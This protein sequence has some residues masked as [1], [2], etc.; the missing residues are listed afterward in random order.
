MTTE[1]N[2]T[3]PW[4]V[5]ESGYNLVDVNLNY[6][7]RAFGV[8]GLGLK[9]GLGE[10][11][12]IAPYATVMALMVQPEQAYE[13]LMT[14]EKDGFGGR[15]GMYE[16]IDYTTARLTR[17]QT[18]AIVRSFM[19]HHQGMAFLS[20]SYLLHDKPM[21]KRFE[22]EAQFKAIMLL[23]QERIPHATE[24]YSPTVHVSDTSITEQEVQMRVITNAPIRLYRKFSYCRM[25]A[26]IR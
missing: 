14:L 24:F 26:I 4:G 19:A 12:V 16:A 5:S 23:L 20:L 17:G 3:V 25:V 1:K 6:Q 13:N 22:S 18:F 9:R 2:A 10:D 21:Q 8:P 15:Y 11:L 7:Y